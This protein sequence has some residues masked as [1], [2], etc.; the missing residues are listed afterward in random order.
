ATISV[1]G[2]GLAPHAVGATVFYTWVQPN[3]FDTLGI[4]LVRGRGFAA[5]VEQGHVAIVSEA[6]ARR[7]W[8]A[9]DPIGQTLRLATT[10]KFHA[11]GELVPDGPTWQVIGVARDTRGVT[12]D[13]S[14]AQQVYLPLPADRVQD[15]PILLRTRV[16]PDLVV[17]RLEPVVA[18]VDPAVTVMATT[19]RTMAEVLLPFSPRACQR[20][21]PPASACVDCCSRRS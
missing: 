1:G 15:Y 6:A 19:L 14:D 17:R 5:P 4:P 8:P 7:L 21:L 18:N 12:M 16:D 9:Q 11:T 20:R 2:D 10:G 13:R 3:Y